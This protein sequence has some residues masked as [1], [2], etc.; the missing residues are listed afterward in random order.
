MSGLDFPQMVQEEATSTDPIS[1][2]DVLTAIRVA[3]AAGEID[4]ASRMFAALDEQQANAQAYMQQQAIAN[5]G[6]HNS[7]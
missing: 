6:I 5:P 3:L 7:H 2:G 4:F 1:P